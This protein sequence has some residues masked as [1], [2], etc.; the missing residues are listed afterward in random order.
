MKPAGNRRLATSRAR[1]HKRAI[2]KKLQLRRLL[3]PTDFS[4]ESVKALRYALS[5]AAEFGAEVRLLHV[6]DPEG[7]PSPAIIRLPLVTQP[8]TVVKMAE[9]L[10]RSQ[11]AKFQIPISAETCVVRQ[12]KPFKTIVATAPEGKA[13]LIVLATRAYTGIKH[14]I[15]GSVAERVVQHSRCPVLIVRKREREF[16]RGNGRAPGEHEMI[17][18]KKILVPVDFSKCSLVG[19][20]YA[21]LLAARFRAALRL[22]HAINPYAKKIGGERIPGETNSLMQAART[23][24]RQQMERMTRSAILREISWEADIRVGSDVDGICAVASAADVDLVVL[25]THGQS[26]LAHALIGSVAEHVVRYATCPL[27]VVPCKSRPSK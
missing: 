9:K 14:L 12:G 10:L 19:L 21:V 20:K 6:V 11:A 1:S 4:R 18:I 15:H 25:S 5:L 2:T 13:D 8:E 16:L 26:G 27:I 24:A 22:F 3:V 7:E 17:S 23:V